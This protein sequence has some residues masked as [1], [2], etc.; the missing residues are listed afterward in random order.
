MPTG[1]SVEVLWTRASIVAALVDLL[2]LGG[3][4][5]LQAFLVVFRLLPRGTWNRVSVI[6]CAAYRRHPIL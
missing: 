1:L 5:S 3:P 4:G 2:S 6:L